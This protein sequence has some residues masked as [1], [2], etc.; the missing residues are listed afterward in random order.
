MISTAQQ[1]ISPLPV[2][3][4]TLLRA[5]RIMRTI[6]EFEERLH[7]EFATGEIP[8]FVHLYAGEEAIAAGVCMHLRDGDRIASTH[9]GHGHC[10][11]KGCD[12][13]AMAAEIYGKES[14]LCRGKGGSMHIA[15][16][17][18]GMMGANGIVGGGP[19]LVCGA[20]LAA[21]KL[22]TKNVAVGFV[23]DGGANQ[24][25]TLESLN[26]AAIWKLP[27]IFVV[28]NNGY[29]EATSCRYSVSVADIAER[30]PAFNMPGIK[31]DGHDFLAVY[32]AAGEAIERARGGGGPTL[33][34]CKVARYFGH[35]EGDTQAYRG[36]DE[37]K[38]VRETRDCIAAL[39]RTLREAGA[40]GAAELEQIERDVV[41]EVDDAIAYAR[42]APYPN[43]SDLLNDVYISY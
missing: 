22:G 33:I 27:C 39:A 37:V 31:V 28:E 42:S 2:D 21:K 41:A 20:G 3:S 30:A 40:A 35:Y 18:K 15:D 19:P 32:E 16:L 43:A 12:L 36:T 5:W 1:S 6:R 7:V 34:E 17:S 10:I 38:K 23:G 14:G 8:G 9:R 4:A 11:A 25:T 26:L 24:G 13:K 29:A